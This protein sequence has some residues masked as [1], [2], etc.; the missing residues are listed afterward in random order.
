MTWEL[1]SD[2]FMILWEA[3][4]LDRMPYPL[5]HRSSA[6]TMDARAMV[7][8]QLRA[9]HASLDD[10][11]LM[12]CIQAL[13]HPDYS[14]TVF[15]PDEADDHAEG[16]ALEETAAV[17]RRGCVRGRIAVMAEQLPG[18][19]GHGTIVLQVSHGTDAENRRWLATQLTAG[20]PDVPPGNIRSLSSTPEGLERRQAGSTMVLHNSAV[21]DG[22]RMR[23]L[24]TRP[25]TSNGYVC[26][27]GPRHGLDEPLVDEMAWFD[28]ADDGRYLHFVDHQVRLRA[29]SLNDLRDE[30]ELRFEKLATGPS[31]ERVSPLV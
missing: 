3:T 31:T 8:R 25:H 30:F 9:W 24:L 11:K 13:R 5:R 19:V 23:R 6:T 17:R 1:R 21:P 10:P 16:S 28:I 14:V 22:D 4:D 26:L 15:V 20:L 18:P 7:E 2:Q 27:L 29:V 12:A